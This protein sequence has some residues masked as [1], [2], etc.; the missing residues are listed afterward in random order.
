MLHTRR[1]IAAPG[2][3]FADMP[4][5]DSFGIDITA[6]IRTGDDVIVRPA[7]GELIVKQGGEV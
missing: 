4:F 5:A 7:A 1:M 6:E 2:A 3:A